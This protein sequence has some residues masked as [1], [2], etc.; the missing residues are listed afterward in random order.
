MRF[1][2]FLFTIFIEEDF[3]ESIINIKKITYIFL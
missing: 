1:L 3:K 2:L